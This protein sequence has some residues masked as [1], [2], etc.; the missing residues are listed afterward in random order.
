MSHTLL[1]LVAAFF[2]GVLNAAAGGGTFLTLPALM[3]TGMP[4]ISANATGTV[5]LLPGY[6]ASVWGFREDL[7]K[8]PISYLL[9]PAIASAFGGAL[10]AGLLLITSNHAFRLIVP[11]L[12]AIAT[13]LFAFGPWLMRR[14]RRTGPAG[15]I[16]M[17]IGIFIVSVY[18]GYFNGG[19]G[20]VILALLGLLGQAD[21]NFMNGYKNLISTILTTIAVVVYAAGGT[22]VWHYALLMM[23]AAIVGGYIGA[24]IARRVAASV[25]RYG[26]VAVGVVTTAVFFTGS[27]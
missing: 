13:L 24:R 20:I 8:Q 9:V 22:V 16:A 17:T 12:M 4:P 7:G 18:G 21:L 27:L 15:P 2:A 14:L 11:W 1:L 6:A 5:A 10:G 19:L 26:I 3:L 25:L 23:T